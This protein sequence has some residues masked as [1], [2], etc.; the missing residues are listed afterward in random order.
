MPQSPIALTG[1]WRG[2]KRH[3]LPAH[4]NNGLEIVFIAAGQSTW[5]A[6]NRTEQI[7]PNSIFF[8]LPWQQH[9]S[10]L[11]EEPGL[12]LYFAVIHLDRSYCKR[13]SCIRFHPQIGL[14]AG[15]ERSLSAALLRTRRHSLT[16]TTAIRWILPQLVEE[17]ARP[18]RSRDAVAGLCRL[19]LVEL[20]RCLDAQSPANR[21]H[22]KSME[23]VRRFVATLPEHAGESW[24]LE[25][26]AKTCGLSRTRFAE[27]AR[28]LTGESPI[29]LLN[30]V[31]ID[32]AKQMLADHQRSI[33]DIAQR[34]GFDSSQ[35]FARVF[36]TYAGCTAREY[37]QFH[38]SG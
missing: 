25:Q 14:C 23:R 9:G 37:R 6:E 1:S 27:L 2:G 20:H 8:T 3:S 18:R 4:H 16:A 7:L 34:A 24:T 19:A 31:R 12:E 35:Y 17:A 38:T 5:Q 11:T 30:R 29:S 15:L 33:T 32:R 36:K 26:M 28:H 10:V 22:S 21:T 13:A